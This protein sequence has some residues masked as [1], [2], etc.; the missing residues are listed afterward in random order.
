MRISR[1]FAQPPHAVFR[2]FADEAAKRRWFA[3]SENA[4][5]DAYRLDFRVGGEEHASG[6]FGAHT[7]TNDCVYHN[8][9]DGERIVHS[10][11]MTVNGAP[12]SISLAAIELAPDGAGTRLSLT[13]HLL[14]LSG[15]D[16]T[17]DRRAGTEGLLTS[18]AEELDR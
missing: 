15:A 1:R 10:Y 17:A 5:V 12:H 4:R 14:F 7:Y 3:E 13:E 16:E 2:A 6:A 11:R 9:V 18:L 8:I